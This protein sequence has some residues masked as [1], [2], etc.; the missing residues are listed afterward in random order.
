MAKQKIK[1]MTAGK[2]DMTGLKK[3]G[4][5]LLITLGAAAIGYIGNL[6]GV[7]DFGSAET[8][9]A[10]T[11]GYKE[12]DDIRKH[13]SLIG[14]SGNPVDIDIRMKDTYSG[15]MVEIK[16]LGLLPSK[17]TFNHPVLISKPK[18][19]RVKREEPKITRT[20][21]YIIPDTPKKG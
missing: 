12:V 17:V 6:A 16:S 3:I 21:S 1:L 13:D 19:I 4:K 20:R 2:L 9:V 15:D 8:L 14:H 11:D 18:H 5:S 10:T 7:I